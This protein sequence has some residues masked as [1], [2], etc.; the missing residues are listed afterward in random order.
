VSLASPAMLARAPGSVGQPLPGTTVR[1]VDEDGSSAAAGRLGRI[2]VRGPLVVRP[3]ADGWL[4]TGDLGRWGEAGVLHVCGRADG[5]FVSGGENVYPQVVEAY[6]LE[7][8]ALAEAAITVVPDAAFGARMRAFVV[9]RP[10]AALTP[11]EVR[12]WL[13]ERLD[14]HQQPKRIDLVETLPRNPLGKLD[15]PALA[16]LAER[17]PD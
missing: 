10:G 13:R 14:R 6:L 2:Q 5:M 9:P 15:R 11:D 7:H 4:D 16:R 3:G 8:T 12:T 1:L 17:D